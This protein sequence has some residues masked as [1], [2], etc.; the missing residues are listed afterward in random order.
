MIGSIGNSR[1]MKIFYFTTRLLHSKTFYGVWFSILLV[2]V[3]GTAILRKNV[4]LPFSNFV[5]Q[6]FLGV[7]KMANLNH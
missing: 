7:I 5:F 1:K 2:I 3:P 6:N 4:A